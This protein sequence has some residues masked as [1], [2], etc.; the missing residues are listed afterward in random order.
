MYYA[1]WAENA[2]SPGTALHYYEQVKSFMRSHTSSKMEMDEFYRLF[3][4]PGM[5]HW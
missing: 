4:V 3:M 1:G 2:I 5:A